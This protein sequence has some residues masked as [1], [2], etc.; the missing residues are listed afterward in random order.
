MFDLK[1]YLEDMHIDYLENES[2]KKYGTMK[3]GGRCNFFVAPEDINKL[4]VV[5]TICKMHNIKYFIIGNASNILFTDKGFDGV[6]IST[7]NIKGITRKDKIVTVK[8]GTMIREVATFCMN[9]ELSGFENLSGIPATVGGACYMNAGAYGSEIKDILIS[10]KVLD[11]D[12]NVFTINRKNMKLSYRHTNFIDDELL[13][14][15]ADFLLKNGSQE[16]IKKA[17]KDTDRRRNEKQP[18]KEKSVGSTFKRPKGE[19][20]YAGK[21]IED[22][23]LKGYSVGDACVSDKHAGFVVN[24]GFATFGEVYE[25]VN[26]IKSSVKDNFCVD[27]ELE[28]IIVGEV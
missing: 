8:C 1:G 16:E 21:L 15:E 5:I 24:K 27:L 18:I 11:K 12:G 2:L 9:N 28:A 25:L 4:I 13:V 23:G 17:I 7:K 3:I 14:L 10:A 6:I 19:G 20:L 22:S 26:H